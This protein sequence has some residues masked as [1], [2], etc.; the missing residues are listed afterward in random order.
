M[1]ATTDPRDVPLAVARLLTSTGRVID[2]ADKLRDERE[3][4]LRL[5]RETPPMPGRPD[6]RPNGAEV[7]RSA[8]RIT[9]DGPPL[10]SD[11]FPPTL[12]AHD[13]RLLVNGPEACR[14]LSVSRKTLYGLT[15]PRGPI[16][17]AT[18]GN[19]PMYPLDELRR[20]VSARQADAARE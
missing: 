6:R 8:L 12:A 18:I 2:A 3:E 9:P 5:L 4:L 15:A 10:P 13:D 19:R 11:R 1:P 7:T 17:A 16:R 20:F 14:L